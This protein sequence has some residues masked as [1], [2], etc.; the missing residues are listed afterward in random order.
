M[1]AVCIGCLGNNIFGADIRT[2]LKNIGT[3]QEREK[4]ILME[5]IRPPSVPGVIWW[6][7]RDH[8]TAQPV[9]N[10]LG[11]FGAYV[12]SIQ[13]NEI[14]VLCPKKMFLSSIFIPLELE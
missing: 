10:E 7:G 13:C 11:I 9:V 14:E 6:R 4:Y 3:S 12:R 1:A 8:A 2:L 5:R